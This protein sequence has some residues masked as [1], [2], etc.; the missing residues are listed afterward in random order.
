[1][2]LLFCRRGFQVVDFASKGLFQ[3]F[4][5]RFEQAA[6]VL[7]SLAVNQRSNSART[8]QEVTAQR[9][10]QCVEKICPGS[11]KL[12]CLETWLAGRKGGFLQANPSL[13]RPPRP[14][15]K[16]SEMVWNVRFGLPTGEPDRPRPPIDW[17]GSIG[18]G[19]DHSRCRT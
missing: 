9:A 3:G 7:G 13:L 14:W 19:L 17:N 2:A 1:M 18:W 5:F 8:G 16:D 6:S 4:P 11:S 12:S 10:R 15:G